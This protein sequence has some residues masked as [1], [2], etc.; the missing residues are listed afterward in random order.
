VIQFEG[1]GDQSISKTFAP[2]LVKV[3]V[4]ADPEQ[5]RIGNDI[6]STIFLTLAQAYNSKTLKVNTVHGQSEIN[7]TVDK[8]KYTIPGQGVRDK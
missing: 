7:F 5:W 3:S 1:L 4:S 6:Y 8:S 2:L